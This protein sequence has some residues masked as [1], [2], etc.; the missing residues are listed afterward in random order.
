M[1]K[2]MLIM[3]TLVL[4][5][6]PIVGCGV[7]VE[8]HNAL[9]IENDAL[10]GEVDTLIIEKEALIAERDA[11]AGERDELLV[12]KDTSV[13]ER[14]VLVAEKASLT[15]EKD[16]LVV[17]NDALV[18][19]KDVLLLEMGVLEVE[20]KNMQEVYPLRGFESLAEF[21]GWIAD[22]I[23]PE[24]T[25]LE[26]WFLASHRVQMEAMA[27]GYLVGVD[28][29]FVGDEGNVA[30]TAFVGNEL[31]WWDVEDKELYGSYNLKR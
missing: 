16:A 30:L 9:I 28:L 5:A 23:Q 3:L 13:L 26:D 18:G 14:N 4:F 15:I 11:L 31:Y 17:E 6:L 20:L 29:D 7:S 21:K 25:Y 19:E 10:V 27:D 2:V 1:K 8:Q 12:A 22:H 24:S